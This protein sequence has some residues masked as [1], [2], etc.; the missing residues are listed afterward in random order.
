[1]RYRETIKDGVLNEG[2]SERLLAECKASLSC[3]LPSDYLQF[4]RK[5]DG[6]E[7]FAGETYIVLWR[8]EELADFNREYEV[9]QY[10]P[11]I[12]LIG[13][14]GGGEAFGFDTHDAAMP[15]V[16]VP[17]VGMDRQLAIAVGDSFSSSLG[18]LAKVKVSDSKK[19]AEL[20]GEKYRGMELFEVKPVILSGDP[21]DPQ[22]KIW[23]T[24]QQHFEL[25]RFWNRLIRD[26]RG[27]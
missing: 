7:G 14:N 25:V 23:V 21:V 17:F 20:P 13:S 27:E 15:V 18:E 19:A 1:M 9:D 12:L 24:R 22:N 10:A 4:L 26:V 11:G 16:R 2:A 5:H 6:G 8:A 3:D